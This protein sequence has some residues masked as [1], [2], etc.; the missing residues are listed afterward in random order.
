M[1]V[2]C[3]L[4]FSS[5]SFE[6]KLPT[7]CSNHS[8]LSTIN[9]KVSYK[10]TIQIK[11][12]ES[13]LMHYYHLITRSHSSFADCPNSVFIAKWPSPEFCAVWNCHVIL[14][15]FWKSFSIF[16]WFYNLDTFGLDWCFLMIRCRI[17]NFYRNITEKMSH[18]YTSYQVVHTFN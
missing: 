5:E 6:I 4:L 16:L 14:V 17:W 9:K 7:G 2:Q 10:I 15:F 13:E 8:W 11:I 1:K 12:R 3:K 18:S